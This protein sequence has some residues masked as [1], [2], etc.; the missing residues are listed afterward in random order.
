MGGRPF[1]F[2]FLTSVLAPNI[3]VHN[4]G[5]G[6]SSELKFSGRHFRS[7]SLGTSPQIS[8]PRFPDLCSGDDDPPP[9]QAIVRIPLSSIWT[10]WELGLDPP[11]PGDQPS[12]TAWASNARWRPGCYSHVHLFLA[13]TL[14]E[15]AS[16][17]RGSWPPTVTGRAGCQVH[18]PSLPV[19]SL[20]PVTCSLATVARLASPSSRRVHA[21]LPG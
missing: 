12:H 18:V 4:V 14:G 11:A 1:S 15:R 16:H 3:Q 6:L 20:P 10:C 7:V 2:F 9:H 19:P 5:F 13:V 17:F 8:D 21:H